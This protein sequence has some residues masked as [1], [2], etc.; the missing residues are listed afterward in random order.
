MTKEVLIKMDHPQMGKTNVEKAKN[1]L[2][3]GSNGLESKDVVKKR[4]MMSELG[5][6]RMC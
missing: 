1:L 6:W 3:S 5:I 4:D 2:F